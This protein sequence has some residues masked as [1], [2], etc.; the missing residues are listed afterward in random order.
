MNRK[1]I[2]APEIR[3]FLSFLCVFLAVL[4]MA[5]TVARAA[6]E[7]RMPILFDAR[8]RLPRPDLSAMLRLRFLT[9]TDFPPF[10]FTDQAGRLSGFHVDLVRAICAELRIE[11]KCQIQAL[12]YG[13]LMAAL[14]GGQGE[15][16]IAGIGVTADLRQRYLFSR[17]YMFLP[18]RFVRNVTKPVAAQDADGLSGRPVGVIAG[19]AHEAMLKGFFPAMKPV[20]FENRTAA[21]EAVRKGDVDALFADAL[22]LSFWVN[23]PASE[24][25]CAL[26]G[27]PYFSERF[28]GEGMAILLRRQDGALTEAI[29]SAFSAISRDGRMQEL[30]LRYFP[31]G[32]Y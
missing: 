20:V 17:P 31:Y 24:K 11:P 32:L 27:G 30:Y 2:I 15:A 22:Q 18:A 10:N 6:E 3:G 4:L 7:P 5:P 23:G 13:D 14:D 1:E 28:L 12:P 25:C 21:L 9:A 8:E 19:T 29:D 26:F 16:V